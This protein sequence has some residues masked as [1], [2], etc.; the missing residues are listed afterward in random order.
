MDAQRR[1]AQTLRARARSVR[2]R[3]SASNA[4]ASELLARA[5]G[6]YLAI[7]PA[8][9]RPSGAEAPSRRTAPVPGASRVVRGVAAPSAGAWSRAFPE[10]SASAA[11]ARWAGCPVIAERVVHDARD[12]RWVVREVDARAVPGTHGDRCLILENHDRVRRLWDYPTSWSRLSDETLLE[13]GETGGTG[14]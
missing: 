5:I 4:R 13:M 7:S 1:R 11:S 3:A 6:V 8:G 12:E 2:A 14:A 10:D 9:R